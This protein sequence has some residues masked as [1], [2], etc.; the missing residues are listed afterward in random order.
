MSIRSARK[1]TRA[2]SQLTEL[3]RISPIVVARRTER[4]SRTAKSASNQREAH[5][6]VQEKVNASMESMVNMTVAA[7][8]IQAQFAAL[9]MRPWL[10]TGGLAAKDSR[11][12]TALMQSSAADFSSSA[13]SPFLRKAKANAKR[14]AG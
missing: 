9:L 8:R 1:Q 10:V 5:L 2:L 12:F 11:S 13:V 4:M 6:M 3:A 7:L 14:L